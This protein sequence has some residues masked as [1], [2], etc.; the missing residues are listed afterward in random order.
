MVKK[1]YD[2]RIVGRNSLAALEEGVR[3]LQYDKWVLVTPAE[4]GSMTLEEALDACAPPELGGKPTGTLL[5]V[6]MKREVRNEN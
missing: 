6:S 5:S 1:K 2:Y 4:D 3:R